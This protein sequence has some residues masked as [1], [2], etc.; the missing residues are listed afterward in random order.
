MLFENYQWRG[1]ELKQFSLFDYT[2]LVSVVKKKTDGNITFSAQ[3]FYSDCMFQRPLK[4]QSLCQVMVALVE[5]FSTN[6]AAED[7]V[8]GAHID[9][10]ARQN[11]MGLILLAL[12]I[13]WQLLP[14]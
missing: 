11:D 13:L 6:K 4:L 7:A 8:S 10:N 1:Q 12:F 5:F 9:T 3:H 2:K 14:A